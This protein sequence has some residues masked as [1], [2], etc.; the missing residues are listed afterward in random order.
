MFARITQQDPFSTEHGTSCDYIP[1]KQ[2]KI[3][4]DCKR[5]FCLD[6]ISK[7]KNKNIKIIKRSNIKDRLSIGKKLWKTTQGSKLITSP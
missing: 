1:A 6:V 7:C 2:V 4:K 5:G 3:K